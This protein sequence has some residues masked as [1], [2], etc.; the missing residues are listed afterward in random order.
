MV[1]GVLF[2]FS[3]QLAYTVG[4]YQETREIMSLQN[5]L[6]AEY[7]DEIRQKEEIKD[8]YNDLQMLLSI[9]QNVNS[10]QIPWSPF[11]WMNCGVWND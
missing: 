4:L 10:E 11:L 5:F 8:K 3:K 6:M 2:Q 9:Q 7:E 1:E